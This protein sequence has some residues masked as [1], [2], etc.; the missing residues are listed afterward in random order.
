MMFREYPWLKELDVLADHVIF[1]V[2][3]EYLA[4]THVALINDAKAFLFPTDVNARS[5]ILGIAV[6]ITVLIGSSR[7]VKLKVSPQVGCLLCLNHLLI[8]CLFVIQDFDKVGRIQ[9]QGLW[10]IATHA[11]EL[12]P[13]FLN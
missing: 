7:T 4:Q 1:F 12:L 3:S 11:T 8:A 6:D 10:G 9:F 5:A 2:V 13:M